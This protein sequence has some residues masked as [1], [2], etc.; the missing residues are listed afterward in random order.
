MSKPNTYVQLLNA[1]KEIARLRADVERMKGFTLQ[2]SLDMA[3]IALNREFGFGP[4]YNERFRNA[5]HATFVEYARMC[6]DDDRDDHEIVYTKEKVD[7][8]LRAAAGPD[9]L[10]F[11]KRYADENLYYRDRLSEPEK[12]AEK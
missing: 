8:A 2:Q 12:G 3:Q 10:P 6:V 9:I 11:D 1:K 5:F 4:K 7:R